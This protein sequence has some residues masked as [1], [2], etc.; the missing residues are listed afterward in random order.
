M[1]S[2]NFVLLPEPSRKRMR[3]ESNISLFLILFQCLC[4]K[5][6]DPL[7]DDPK[8]F[9]K[10]S[11]LLCMFFILNLI[12]NSSLNTSFSGFTFRILL[13]CLQIKPHNCVIF[14][15]FLSYS[16]K[17]TSSDI[18]NINITTYSPSVTSFGL[19]HQIFTIPQAQLLA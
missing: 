10:K 7:H 4:F 18:I 5:L 2:S 17:E 3:S 16:N 9:K 13:I 11:H 14:F 1:M 6:N 8:L 15:Y 19:I 12:K